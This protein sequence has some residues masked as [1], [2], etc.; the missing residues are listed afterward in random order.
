[1]RLLAVIKILMMSK[2]YTFAGISLFL[3]PNN[4]PVT[5]G[6]TYEKFSSAIYT[7]FSKDYMFSKAIQSDPLRKS[8]LTKRCTLSFNLCLRTPAGGATPRVLGRQLPPPPLRGLRP[9]ASCQRYEPKE[10]NGR[11]RRPGV[12]G[13]QRGYVAILPT[14]RLFS[15]SAPRSEAVGIP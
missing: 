12:E 6:E 1:M 13:A 15:D 8:I 2:S 3:D 9:T 11:R 4:S 5:R 10:P 7:C 14:W